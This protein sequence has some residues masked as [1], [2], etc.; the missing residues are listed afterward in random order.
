[1]AYEDV[2]EEKVED[3]EEKDEDVEEKDE[4]VEGEKEEEEEDCE[5]VLWCTI[6]HSFSQARNY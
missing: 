6:S 2:E 4:D 5:D 3:E 1:M